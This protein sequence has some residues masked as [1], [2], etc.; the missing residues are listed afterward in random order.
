MSLVYVRWTSRDREVPRAFAIIAM[1]ASFAVSL[2]VLGLLWAAAARQQPGWLE[3]TYVGMAAAG[4]LAGATIYFVVRVV[5][6][7]LTASLWY[8]SCRIPR[9]IEQ[10]WRVALATTCLALVGCAAAMALIFVI[11]HAVSPHGLALWLFPFFVSLFPLYETF[12]LPWVQYARAPTLKGANLPEL[13]KWIEDLAAQRDLPKLRIRVQNGQFENAF[14]IGGVGAHLVVL[15]KGLVDSMSPAHLRAVVAHEIAH[16]AR[17]DVPRL[18]LPLVVAAGTL[19]AIAVVKFSHP[20]FATHEPWG[21][22]SGA[23]L[24][25]LFAGVFMLILPGFFMRRIEFAADRLAAEML[26]DGEV[27]A[28]ALERLGEITGERLDAWSWSHPPL[29]ARIAALRSPDT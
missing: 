12:V 4:A 24:T 27:L 15:G 28:Q 26:G 10:T 6:A 29:Q 18:L 5:I 13:D 8:W 21:V 7:Q 20:L 17:R 1:V 14:A 2:A 3:P 25:G 19:H 11:A 9:E 16:V 23:I 22:A